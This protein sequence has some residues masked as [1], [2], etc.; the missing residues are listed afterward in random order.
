MAFPSFRRGGSQDAGTVYLRA[1]TG[2]FNAKVEQ[3]ERQWRESVSGMSREALKL[4]LAQNRLKASLAKYGAESAQA[5]RA[6]IALK[7]AEE[8]ATRSTQRLDQ[9][10]DR[11]RRGIVSLRSAAVATAG[12]VG[13]YGLASA[14]RSTIA[15]ASEQELVLGQTKV[16]LEAA[17]LS[18]EQ[19]G[20][21]VEQALARQSKLLAFDDEALAR[22]FQTFIRQTKDVEEALRRNEL[23]ADVARGRYMSLEQATQLVTKAALGQAGALRRVGID[24]AGAKTGVELLARL[25]EQYGQA[26]E[27]AATTS[28]AAQDRWNVSLENAREVIGTALLPTFTAYVGKLTEYVDKASESGDLQRRVNAILSDAE[29]IV[30]GLADGFQALRSATAPVVGALGGLDKAVQT[31]L[32]LGALGK[33]RTFA[34][35]FGLVTAASATARTKVAADAAAMNASMSG[36]ARGLGGLN[37]LLLLGVGAQVAHAQFDEPNTITPGQLQ[38]PAVRKR[39]VDAFGREALAKLDAAV[40][41]SGLASRPDEGTRGAYPGPGSGGSGTTTTRR[42]RTTLP[43]GLADAINLAALTTGLKDD[44]AAAGGV[45]DFW[46]AQ[47]SLA[48]KG[49]KAYSVIL[50]ELVAANRAVES[51]EDQLAAEQKRHDDAIDA[52]RR[53]AAEEREAKAKAAAARRAR[54]AERVSRI[55]T[56]GPYATTSSGFASGG[57]SPAAAAAKKSTEGAAG[58]LTA[59]DVSRQIFEFLSRFEELN[60][61]NAGTNVTVNQT[62]P[63][64][65]PDRAMEARY[66]R[67]GMEAAFAG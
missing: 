66:A 26:A 12:A 27:K 62:F 64:P 61:R 48:K 29:G 31:F 13:V 45:R 67:W 35:G 2:E 42:P 44:L 53:K 25:T 7:D 43:R 16:A 36:L 54:D 17:G 4:D 37:G 46:R 39:I 21:R 22:S 33:L 9:A 51:I 38:D 8:A 14:I 47:L 18:W 6:T 50:S 52:K 65:T 28:Q 58:G 59:A 11:T 34:A 49:T 5:K 24:T 57:I 1:D 10:H 20:D 32:V 40:Q 60:R 55:L 56:P 63:A 3:A 41:S 23:A 30:R 15:A 19:Y